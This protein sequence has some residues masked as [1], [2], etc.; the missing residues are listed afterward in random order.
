MSY[1]TIARHGLARVDL[2]TALFILLILTSMGL[3]VVVKAVETRNRIR[4]A[5]NLRQIGLGILL[6][7]NEN[8]GEYPRTVYDVDHTDKP[9]WGTGPATAGAADPFDGKNGPDA[10]DVSAAFFLLL[11]TEDITPAVFVCP[12]STEHAWDYGGHANTAQ[13]WVNWPKETLAKNLSYSYTNPYPSK[14]AAKSGYVLNMSLPPD[15]AVAAD[16]NPGSDLLTKIILDSPASQMRKC[17]SPNHNG[18]G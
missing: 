9:V 3:G 8:K 5:T 4:C 17:N 7:A 12:S 1:R 10:N 18:D 14:A 6:Y 13:N 11:R 16:I 15:F 2:I